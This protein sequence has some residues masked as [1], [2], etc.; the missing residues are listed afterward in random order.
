[1]RLGKFFYFAT[2]LNPVDSYV[3]VISRSWL[4]GIW[5]REVPAHHRNFTHLRKYDFFVAIIIF[6]VLTYTPL[7]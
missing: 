2:S 7:K 5:F 1:M 4:Y 6:G 3:S